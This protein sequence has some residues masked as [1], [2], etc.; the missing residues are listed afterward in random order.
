[1]TVQKTAPNDWDSTIKKNGFNL[2]KEKN[3]KKLDSRTIGLDD[4]LL[5]S[6]SKSGWWCHSRSGESSCQKCLETWGLWEGF[7]HVFSVNPWFQ[8]L[9][10]FFESLFQ[11]LAPLESKNF[12]TL[13][14]GS[15]GM[16]MAMG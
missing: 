7:E 8:R 5:D 14:P 10:A 16:V 1:M 13:L 6:K 2:P 12:A 3:I 11:R 15:D 4:G 9:G